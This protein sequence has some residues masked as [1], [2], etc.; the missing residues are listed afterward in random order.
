MST[1]TR[2]NGR[3]NPVEQT[4]LTACFSGRASGRYSGQSGRRLGAVWAGG[5]P[6]G[7]DRGKDR[8]HA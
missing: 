3:C 4:A 1:K 7:P 8:V 2:H 6:A 5:V